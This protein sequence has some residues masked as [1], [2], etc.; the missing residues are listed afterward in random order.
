MIKDDLVPQLVA[1]SHCSGLKLSLYL[2][3]SDTRSK[4]RDS[5]KFGIEIAQTPDPSSNI[6]NFILNTSKSRSLMFLIIDL[7]G[8][9]SDMLTYGTHAEVCFSDERRR[10]LVKTLV[11]TFF[12][13]HWCSVMSSPHGRLKSLTQKCSSVKIKD[14]LT[15]GRPNQIPK[16]QLQTGQPHI[17]WC[18]LL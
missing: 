5:R 4:Q 11:L 7:L 18:S 10:Y 8:R 1:M 17:R 9:S 15:F 12:I 16:F 6:I 3:R 13:K 2:R 14:K